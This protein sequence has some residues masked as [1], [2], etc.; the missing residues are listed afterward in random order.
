LPGAGHNLDADG[1]F[2][3]SGYR[4]PVKTEIQSFGSD[5]IRTEALSFR[6]PGRAIDTSHAATIALLV[7]RQ[8]LGASLVFPRHR[9]QPCRGLRMRDL[10]GNV[11]APGGMIQQGAS[12]EVHA[13][14]RPT[15]RCVAN[16]SPECPCDE[17]SDPGKSGNLSA[18]LA[19]AYELCIS[20]EIERGG[21]IPTENL[22]LQF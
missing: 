9:L 12:L 21:R 8:F 14:Q 2:E 17:S 22:E 15:R 4:K 5:S 19:F 18:Q 13:R 1:V 10:A 20:R 11:S 3:R 16:T 6:A 7:V